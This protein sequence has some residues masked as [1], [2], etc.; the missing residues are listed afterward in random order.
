MINKLEWKMGFAEQAAKK[1]HDAET[2][3]G[4]ALFNIK[5]G[6]LISIGYNGF[7]RGADDSKLPTTRP[8]KYKFIIHAESNLIVNC[9]RNGHSMKDSELFCT[10]SP[11]VQC[12]RLLWQA[13]VRTVYCKELYRDFHEIFEMKD[14]TLTVDKVYPGYYKIIYKEFGDV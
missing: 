12:M 14:I 6:S 1:S 13:G 4:A 10:M 7:V 11:C 5:D 3:V 2:Q 9:A 8:D